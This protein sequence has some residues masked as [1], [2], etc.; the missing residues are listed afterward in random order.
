MR[1]WRRFAPDDVRLVDMP[2]PDPG[3]GEALLRP[4]MSGVCGTDLHVLHGEGLGELP[5]P[6]TMGHEVCGE[7]VAL[8]PGAD[9]PG[10]YPRT[11]AVLRVGDRV[12]VEPVLPC[13]TCYFCR[14][15]HPNVCPRMSHLGVWR[16]G[17]YADFV[18]VPAWRATRLPDTM[19]T[20][21]GL[22]VEV[23][24]CGL[25]CVDQAQLKAGD[26][27]L[28]IGGGPMGQMAAQCLIAAGAVIVMLS[29]PNPRRRQL[30]RRAGV[31]ATFSPETDDLVAE[32]RAL[33]GGLGA[34]VVIECVGLP[35]TVQQALDAT[36]RRG[37]CVLSGL[38]SATVQMDITELV[39]GEKHVVGSLA[40]AWQFERAIQLIADG[41]LR[42]RLI[43]EEPRAF[44]ALP[45]ALADARDRRD[46]GKIVVAHSA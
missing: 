33:T 9:Q 41:K 34:D 42:P 14:R 7:V 32:V 10:P 11:S 44:N 3:P 13:G 37:T 38:P 18:C 45:A 36:R 28:V 29:E 4:L 26:T 25:N 22:L 19:D 43:V 31:H 17:N 27:A 30:A 40:S 5:V 35:E 8:G 12:V 1:A 15:G 23:S 39:F 21:S 46:L 16:D 6:L 2:R 24:A 20:I